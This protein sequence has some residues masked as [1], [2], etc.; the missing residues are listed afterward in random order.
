MDIRLDGNQ[1][2]ALIDALL[3][4][5]RSSPP[6]E[7]MLRLRLD[8]N[9]WA[10]VS[11]SDLRYMLFTLVDRSQAEG[12]TAKLLAAA[13]ADQ[14]GNEQLRQV[15]QHFGI[16]AIDAPKSGL[17]RLVARSSRFVDVA[18]FLARAMEI[19]AQVCKVE[20]PVGRGQVV[21]GTGFLVGPAAVLTAHHV[22]EAAI[23][24]EQ[25][26]RTAAG[27]AARPAD[28]VL[29]FDYKRTPDGNEIDRGVE[30]RLA[31]DDWLIAAAPPSAVDD[32]ADPGDQL[33]DP[34]ELD[35]ALLRLA[36]P[37]G[38]HQIGV[39]AEPAP[40]AHGTPT[41][42]WITLPAVAPAVDDD[43]SVLIM[44]HPDGWPLK[45]A[46]GTDAMLGV[47]GNG[48]RVRYA[49][50][51]LGGSSGAPV[52]NINWELIALHHW[53]DPNFN[54]AAKFNQGV[55]AAAIR[56]HLAGLG[57]LVALA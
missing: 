7:M 34:G 52:F 15:A 22:V 51:T 12:W 3:D 33:P 17:E 43:A 27:L 16:G 19:E 6:L 54:A 56:A 20:T 50:S 29:R 47:N 39:Q 14:P 30:Y 11:N 28:V 45:L 35:F 38:R 31:A 48:T 21:T 37:A 18:A 24:G 55:P 25:G 40:T 4:A 36:S 53:G 44:Q 1:Y 41:R 5:Y 42:G 46:M 32:L 9:L 13:R 57:K 26:R 8:K 23:L 2:R 10:Y 49:T